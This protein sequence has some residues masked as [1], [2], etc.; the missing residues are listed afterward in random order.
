MMEWSNML[1]PAEGGVKDEQRQNESFCCERVAAPPRASRVV[2]VVAEAGT[3]ARR[4]PHARPRSPSA[5]LHR[6]RAGAPECVG[7]PQAFRSSREADVAQSSG[8]A[9]PVQAVAAWCL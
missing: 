9:R 7:A 2:R 1:I 5:R 3:A 6:C 8:R 4:T